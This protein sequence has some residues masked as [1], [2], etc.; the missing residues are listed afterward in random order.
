MRLH[1][2]PIPHRFEAFQDV[3]DLKKKTKAEWRRKRSRDGS[4]LRVALTGSIQRSTYEDLLKTLHDRNPR[5][6][7]QYYSRQTTVPRS[8]LFFSTPTERY[9]EH[10]SGTRSDQMWSQ[11]SSD[12]YLGDEMRSW[13]S[14][15]G[16]PVAAT[17]A[18]AF[19]VAGG[20]TEVHSSRWIPSV[21]HR[22]SPCCGPRRMG[23]I[24]RSSQS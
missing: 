4:H 24:H 5:V 21:S 8:S 2:A 10:L 3:G 12:Q 19:A 20:G 6:R 18:G 1:H 13:R 7:P 14:R 17:G 23:R 22:N 9:L 11:S 15:A 16:S